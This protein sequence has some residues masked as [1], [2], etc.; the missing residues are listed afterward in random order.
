MCFLGDPCFKVHPD[1]CLY[2]VCVSKTNKQ[3]L[4]ISVGPQSYNRAISLLG[5]HAS[6][7]GPLVPF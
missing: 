3:N 2:A 5:Q 6:H 1:L 7:S 4:A